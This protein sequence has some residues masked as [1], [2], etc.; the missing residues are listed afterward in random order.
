V[1]D[2]AYDSTERLNQSIT[3]TREINL[4]WSRIVDR[5][6]KRTFLPVPPEALPSLDGWMA[7]R[8]AGSPDG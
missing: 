5:N 7:V 3:A 4:P 2:T 6:C 1:M 8:P